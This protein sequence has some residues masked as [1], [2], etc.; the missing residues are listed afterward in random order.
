MNGCDYNAPRVTELPFAD[1]L[2]Q[3]AY[4]AHLPVGNSIGELM[5]KLCAAWFTKCC[6]VVNRV[7]CRLGLF[8]FVIY[9]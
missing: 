8:L 7:G 6:N 1:Q 3:I 9:S 2:Q 4:R 5:A